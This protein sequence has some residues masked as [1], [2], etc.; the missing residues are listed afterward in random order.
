MAAV[1]TL[2]RATADDAALLAN[3]LELYIHDMSEI[4]A[5]TPGPDGRFGY[6]KLPL[7]WSTPDTHLAYLVRSDSAAAGFALVTRG[8]PATDDPDDLDLAE[9]F[10]LRSY[11]RTGVGRRAAVLLWDGLR[12]HWIVRVSERNRGGLAFWDSVIRSYTGGAF[13]EKPHPGQS[14][15]FRVF[16]FHS[17]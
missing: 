3:L 8:S 11:R 2:A 4:F 6:G 9:F 16:M 14:H 12:G 13:D 17:R 10:V 7:Y 1:T 15:M 5:V